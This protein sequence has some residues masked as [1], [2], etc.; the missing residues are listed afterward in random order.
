MALERYDFGVS[1]DG[2]PFALPKTG[3]KIARPFRGGR[4][5]LRAE[6]AAMFSAEKGTVPSASA[7]A[8][9]LTALEGEAMA[10]EPQPL[11]TR[12]AE[13]DNRLYLDLGRPDGHVVR[14]GAGGWR[15]V[16]ESPVLF[17]RT[18]LTSGLPDPLSRGGSFDPLRARLN[19]G[20]QDWPLVVAWLLAALMADMPHPVLSLIGEQGTGKSTATELLVNIVDPSPAPLRSA[21]RDVEQWSVT[22]NASW[23]VGLD[24][25]SGLQ[26]WLSDVLC[27]AVTGDGMVRRLL[28]SDGDVSVLAFRRC[29]VT[30]GIDLG[31]VRGDLADRMLTVELQRITSTMR[32]TAADV[33][34]TD[35]ERAQVLGALLDLGVEVLALL[36]GIQL[37]EMP[38]MADFSRVVA[39]TDKV[40][41]TDGLKRYAA[42]AADLASAVVDADPFASAVN[43]FLTG[44]ESGSWTGTGGALLEMLVQ[45]EPRPRQ[46]PS[47]S[48]RAN[49]ALRRVA[50]ALR[51]AADLD[52]EESKHPRTRKTVWLITRRPTEIGGEQA[53]QA[54]QA[55]QPTL[56]CGDV[57]SLA[58]TQPSH[59]VAQPSHPPRSAPGAKP[60]NDAAKAALSSAFAPDMP[61]DLQQ[62]HGAKPAKPAKPPHP[63]SLAATTPAHDPDCFCRDCTEAQ[64]P[65]L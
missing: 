28:Y 19:V 22:A 20:E 47:D 64:E 41:G 34:I 35:L 24:N 25:I 10:A 59:P 6:L 49:A 21:P 58:E 65:A 56:T 60:D 33:S 9:A 52:I 36:P 15:I 54:S 43:T 44:L 40:L 61:S 39:A 38:R 42:Q 53:S 31:A 51:E 18:A 63:A 5:G 7:L 29:I 2:A 1:L 23:V 14:I 17:K 48:Q 57:R 4:T 37:L 13:H 27:R 45:P 11:A 50:P 8:D 12:V 62:H 3:P 46:W 16:D 26:P 30:N 55:S 32:R